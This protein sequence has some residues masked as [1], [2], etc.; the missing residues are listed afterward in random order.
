M[1]FEELMYFVYMD[2]QEKTVEANENDQQDEDAPH[3]DDNKKK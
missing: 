3:K 1:D 2:E